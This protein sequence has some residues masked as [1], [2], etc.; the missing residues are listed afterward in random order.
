MRERISGFTIVELI[1][2]ILILG[3]LAATALPRFMDIDDEAHTSVVDGIYGGM[4]TGLSLYHATWI[5]ER[6]PVAGAAIADFNSLRTNAS[7]YPYGLTDTAADVV[8][9]SAE[10]L[11]VYQGIL[12]AGAPSG[13]AAADAVAVRGSTTDITAV[14]TGTSCVFYYTGQTSATGATVA[15]LTYNSVTGVIAR[16]TAVL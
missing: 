12:Q 11:E 7:G 5:A 3:I 14:R 15:T 9:T 2:V 4:Q 6:Q 10:C 8:A 16:A 1:V 13:S